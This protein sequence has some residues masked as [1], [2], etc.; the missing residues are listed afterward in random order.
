ML[1][2]PPLRVAV[3]RGNRLARQ[4]ARSRNERLCFGP[5][6]HCIKLC[7]LRLIDGV[8]REVNGLKRVSLSL[9]RVPRGLVR[10]EF[11]FLRLDVCPHLRDMSLPRDADF[12]P[13]RGLFFVRCVS[14]FWEMIGSCGRLISRAGDVSLKLFPGPLTS[15]LYLVVRGFRFVGDLLELCAQIGARHQE[16]L[17]SPQAGSPLLCEWPSLSGG[18][19]SWTRD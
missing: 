14:V 15:G 17:L 18:T 3:E 13:V 7:I 8:L 11:G 4:A 9:V 16:L 5:C 6:M 1:S 2:R 19:R 10:V 12:S